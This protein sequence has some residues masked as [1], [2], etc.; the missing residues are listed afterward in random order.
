VFANLEAFGRAVAGAAPY[1]ITGEE[2][3]ANITLLETIV[4]ASGS[5]K[6]EPV[7]KVDLTLQRALAEAV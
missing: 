3:I 1:P 5:G 2:M 6:V 4:R 7:D